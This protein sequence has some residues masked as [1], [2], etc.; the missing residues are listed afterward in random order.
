MEPR[1]WIGT[2]SKASLRNIT[3]LN[4]I[5]GYLFQGLFCESPGIK[6][7]KASFLMQRY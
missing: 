7:G 5:T 2:P 1:N 4:R 3:N 6:A